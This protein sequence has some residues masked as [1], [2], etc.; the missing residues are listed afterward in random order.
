MK[1]TRNNLR[2]LIEAF[3]SGPLG[4]KHIPDEDYPYSRLEKQVGGDPDR[5]AKVLSLARG[6]EVDKNQFKAIEMGIPL[7]DDEGN[8]IETDYIGDTQQMLNQYDRETYET[9]AT[10]IKEIAKKVIPDPTF[11]DYRPNKR[12]QSMSLTVVI[13]SDEEEVGFSADEEALQ[14]AE[15]FV[16]AIK[17]QGLDEYLTYGRTYQDVAAAR[18][19][20]YIVKKD[21]PYKMSNQYEIR[22]SARNP[23]WWKG[24]ESFPS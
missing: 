22:F 6:N 3:I 19:G 4:T 1:L 16:L 13:E 2:Q 24:S 23:N 14:Y 12:N 17:Q 9:F 7:Y 11:L 21:H 15:E 5:M 10:P 18:K 20:T 8:Q